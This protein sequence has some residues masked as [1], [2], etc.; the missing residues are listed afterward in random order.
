MD[1]NNRDNEFQG[2]EENGLDENH[3]IDDQNELQ[4]NNL[5][6]VVHV[7]Y[8]NNEEDIHAAIQRRRREEEARIMELQREIAQIQG[9]IMDLQDEFRRA[10]EDGHR[11]MRELEERG[12]QPDWET[13]TF[14]ALRQIF[15]IFVIIVFFR[16]AHYVWG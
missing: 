4:D 13:V 9:R 7:D 11:E 16:I 14:L 12:F 8:N 2:P 6:N 1:N 15:K 5:H 10:L 3:D